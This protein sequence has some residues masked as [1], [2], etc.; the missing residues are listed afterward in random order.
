M[1]EYADYRDGT[2]TSAEL[3]RWNPAA[4]RATRTE[5]DATD[6]LVAKLTAAGVEP[7]VLDR[8]LSGTRP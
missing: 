3:W 5:V 4:T 1:R 8:D 2:V 7:N 6:R